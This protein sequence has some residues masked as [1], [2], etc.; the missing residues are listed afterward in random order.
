M[1]GSRLTSVNLRFAFLARKMLYTIQPKF[2]T[3]CL[4]VGF[5]I[6][7]RDDDE[8]PETMLGVG[9]L[10]YMEVGK[11]PAPDDLMKDE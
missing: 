7:G 4:N 3:M 5:V 1:C 11:A 10:T 8:L 2:P 6:E 9:K